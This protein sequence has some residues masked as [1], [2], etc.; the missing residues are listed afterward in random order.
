MEEY[1]Y[2]CLTCLYKTDN[3]ASLKAHYNT[4]MH[5]QKVQKVINDLQ[6]INKKFEE[7]KYKEVKLWFK[8]SKE[9]IEKDKQKLMA[10]KL[11]KNI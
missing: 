1:K 10:I 7:G 9:D 3:D 4:K 11:K 6:E 2:K 5:K 8:K